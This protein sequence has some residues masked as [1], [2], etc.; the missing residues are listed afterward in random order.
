MSGSSWTLQPGPDSPGGFTR[1]LV[2]SDVD[3][4]SSGKIVDVDGSPDPSTRRVTTTVSWGTP[5]ATSV[6]SSLYL[7]RYLDNLTDGD[8]TKAQFDQGITAGTAVTEADDGE[9]VL[10]GGGHGDW[11]KPDLTLAQADLPKN[12]VAN[13]VSAIPATETVPGYAFAGTGDN[14]SGVAFG[15]VDIADSDPPLATASGT[16]DP[17]HS[18]KTNGVFGETSY[19]Y[20]ATDNNSKE[21]EIINLQT[22]P[23]SEAGWFN[24]PGNGNGNS[25]YVVGNTGYMTSADKFY[26]FNLSSNRSGD[27]GTPTA[28]V[29]LTG[30]GNKVKVVSGFA[31]VAENSSSRQ[32]EII[33]LSTMTVVGWANNLNNQGATSVFVDDSGTWAYL[34]TSNSSSGPELFIINVSTKTGNHTATATADMGGMSPKDVVAVTNNKVIAVGTGSTEYQVFTFLNNALTTCGTGLNLDTGINGIAAVIQPSGS[35]FSYIITGDS[36]TEFKIIQGG[37]SGKTSSS[38]IFESRTFTFINPTAFNHLS[39]TADLP[40]GTAIRFQSAVSGDCSSY[41]YV[42]VDAS[43]AIPFDNPVAGYTNPGRCFRYKA[44]LTTASTLTTP[45]L[46]DVTINYSP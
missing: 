16:F 36:T 7:T 34:V 1:S 45:I 23:Y 18:M 19:A 29:T 31:Y 28:T 13:A 2:I 39:Y 37:P 22:N 10:S 3:R 24:A 43:G 21:I 41:S 14:A 35:A 38:G 32:L 25:V 15:R 8:D 17:G 12:G 5:L 33:D 30:T 40:G 9:V 42:D 20:L 44:I 11:C 4:D 27:Q 46:Y 26:A 6:S